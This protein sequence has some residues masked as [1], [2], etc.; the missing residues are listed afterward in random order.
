MSNNTAFT[1]ENVALQ[2][3]VP[4]GSTGWYAALTTPG[5]ELSRQSYAD[6]I[7]ERL[8]IALGSIAPGAT[9]T[10]A[11]RTHI[12]GDAQPG[13]IIDFNAALVDHLGAITTDNI[14]VPVVADRALEL[15]LTDSADPVIPGTELTYTLDFGFSGSQRVVEGAELALHLPTG[16]TPTQLDAGGT[17]DGDWVR[18]SL[19][20]LAPGEVGRRSLR[21][22]V[23]SSLVAGHSL[24]TEARLSGI[25]EETTHATILTAVADS[26]PITLES[27]SLHTPAE[28][29]EYLPL[30]FTVSNNTAFTREN[31]ALQLNVPL[32]STGW[33][34]ALT[35]P[36]FELSR[37]S[38]ADNIGERLSIAL[39][40]IA[41]G[42]TKTVALRTHIHGDAQ[43]GTIID[44]NAALVDHLGAIT[45]DNIQVPVVADRAL[46]LSLTDSAD[47][48]IPG[49]EL[50]YTLDFGFSGSQRVV[51]GAELALHLPTGVTPTQLDAGGTQDG[52]WVRWPLGPL[53]PGEVGQR[54]LM[55]QVASTLPA[56]ALLTADA[57]LTGNHEASW[58]TENTAL[59]EA[60]PLSVTLGFNPNPALPGDASRLVATVANNTGFDRPD[61][62]LQIFVP[63]GTLGWYSALTTPDYQLIKQSYTDDVGERLSINLGTLR[64]NAG[65]QLSLPTT[66]SD[67]FSEGQLARFDGYLF[68]GVGG[69]AEAS[70]RVQVGWPASTIA[71]SIQTTASPGAGGSVS[72]DPN[73]VEQGGS[74]VCIA[75]VN[76]G[77]RFTGWSGDCSGSNSSCT[78]N[79]VT[80]SRSVTAGFS[81]I[82]TG[83]HSITMVA[84]PA[85]GG[86]IS[87]SPNPV[88]EGS[89]STCTAEPSEGYS[90]T[91]W[92]GDCDGSNPSCT[93]NNVTVPQ[94]VFASFSQTGITTEQ[95]ARTYVPGSSLTVT[96]RFNDTSGDTPRSLV[97]TPELPSGWRITSVSG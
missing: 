26:V 90:F 12:H 68:D 84:S 67:G 60:Q 38:Y 56:G 94:R 65:F 10:V 13:T 23:D 96:G 63:E 21:V 32:G 75:N 73:P 59:E 74:S 24:I 2:L 79:N 30:T 52:D 42:A 36:G 37:Q 95:S 8:S 9:K 76:S 19:G 57:I 70:Y 45:T 83:D 39:G 27:A 11:L 97:W 88:P 69:H 93:L 33:Y 20:P 87:C 16:V 86:S 82:T 5:F 66:I 72:C 17:Q 18:W 15:S 62:W 55:V 77:Y 61:A 64:A 3:N 91:R 28:P 40:S 53:A 46:E 44:F 48:V 6:N 80:A 78:L 50:T 71:Y 47:P 92:S 85:A 7:G 25:A 51:E 35:T 41:P 4:L 22:S 58:V 29:G 43:P 14:Q 81:R 1:R 49:T 34:A 31:V 89:S 54:T